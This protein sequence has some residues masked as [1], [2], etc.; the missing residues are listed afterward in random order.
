MK[1][2][3]PFL[4]VFILSACSVNS[5]KEI[6]LE[7]I[8]F[9]Y[10]DDAYIF[11]RN[12]RQTNYSIE[13]LEDAGWRI[14]RH[15]DYSEDRSSFD[16]KTALV[17]NWRVNKVYPIIELPVTFNK[18]GLKIMWIDPESNQSGT[19]ILGGLRRKEEMKLLTQ[20]YNHIIQERELRWTPDG[21]NSAPLFSDSEKQEAFRVT[22]YDFYRLTGL[23]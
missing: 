16:F 21:E 23:L 9:S 5:T 14:Y 17:V 4:L 18:E 13:I 3:I 11:F 12:M 1:R 22:M 15:E 6:D 19:V 8:T 10:R 7:K 2:F 20:I